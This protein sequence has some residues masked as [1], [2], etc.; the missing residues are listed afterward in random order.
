[1]IFIRHYLLPPSPLPYGCG[2]GKRRVFI[3][4]ILD[5]EENL[6]NRDANFMPLV[7]EFSK[8]P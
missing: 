5:G 4:S 2:K 6:K 7:K 8:S 1:L 3:L